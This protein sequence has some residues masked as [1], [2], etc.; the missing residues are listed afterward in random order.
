WSSDVCSS[1]LRGSSTSTPPCRIGA[2]IM[3][4][5]SSTNATSTRFVILISELTGRRLRCRR[6]ICSMRCPSCPALRRV[7]SRTRRVCRVM[8]ATSRSASQPALACQRADELARETLHL[9]AEAVQPVREVVV[10]DRRRDRRNE[11]ARRRDQRL[12]DTGRSEEHTSELQSRENLVCRLL[13]EKK[14][15]SK[16]KRQ[17]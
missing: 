16:Q 9:S 6:F 13:L 10:R 3:K 8:D 14:K 17:Q 15:K 5:I 4:M 7:P 2:V 12:G 11:T 1:D